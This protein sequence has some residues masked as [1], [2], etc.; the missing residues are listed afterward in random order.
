ML[1]LKTGVIE[2]VEADPASLLA[3]RSN[4]NG[5]GNI[6]KGLG[7]IGSEKQGHSPPGPLKKPEHAGLKNKD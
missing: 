2:G 1:A 5:W 6:W 3:E 7:L 4:G